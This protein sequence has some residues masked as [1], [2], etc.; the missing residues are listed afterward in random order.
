MLCGS[1][2]GVSRSAAP[3]CPPNGASGPRAC[4]KIAQ[5]GAEPITVWECPKLLIPNLKTHSRIL[6]KPLRQLCSWYSPWTAFLHQTATARYHAKESVVVQR[7]IAIRAY[8]MSDSAS[9]Y[10][11]LVSFGT[12]GLLATRQI[13][14]D[15]A[16]IGT[17]C[18]HTARNTRCLVV[19]LELNR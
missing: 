5:C 6:S 1:R 3:M 9:L 2:Q 18:L 19:P 4:H 11:L 10:A 14:G 15:I 8:D 12:A 16:C 13:L 7:D 17:R